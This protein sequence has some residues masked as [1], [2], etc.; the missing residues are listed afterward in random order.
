MAAF[1][2]DTHVLKIKW[3][4]ILSAIPTEHH[5]DIPC[6]HTTILQAS[7]INMGGY[8]SSEKPVVDAPGTKSNLHQ[9]VAT[10]LI[11]LCHLLTTVCKRSKCR[12]GLRWHHSNACKK[13]GRTWHIRYTSTYQAC[14]ARGIWWRVNGGTG[15]NPLSPHDSC[16]FIKWNVWKIDIASKSNCATGKIWRG[17]VADLMI[18]DHKLY[19]VVLV[20]MLCNPWMYHLSTVQCALPVYP[21][22]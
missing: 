21:I 18:S 15:I 3:S 2:H 5:P 7:S 10:W 22:V 13:I 16:E 12:Y 4:L 1:T 17:N 14:C 19:V 9:E 20:C 6:A 11:R 8:F